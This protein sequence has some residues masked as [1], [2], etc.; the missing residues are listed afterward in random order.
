MKSEIPSMANR[1]RRCRLQRYLV[2]TTK[3]QSD[4]ESFT[5][6]SDQ[7]QREGREPIVQEV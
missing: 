6:S 1:R 4:S 7:T 2:A 3:N 5:N